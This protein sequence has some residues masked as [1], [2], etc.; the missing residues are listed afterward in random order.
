MGRAATT[1]KVEEIDV[2]AHR[3]FADAGAR[4]ATFIKEVYNR[5]RLH[6]RLAYRSPI[7][8][9]QDLPFGRL[10][11]SGPARLN[12]PSVPNSASQRWGPSNRSL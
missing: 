10:L 11:R 2:R 8:F 9:E 3:D 7:E 12:S 6:S 4:V 5:Q 1:V